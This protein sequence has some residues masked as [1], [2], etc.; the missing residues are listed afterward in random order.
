MNST[1]SRT[2]KKV[3]PQPVKEIARY[4]A[5]SS[6]LLVGSGAS[7]IF[8]RLLTERTLDPIGC[9][10][11]LS[12]LVSGVLVFSF[13]RLHRWAY[14]ILRVIIIASGPNILYNRDLINTP[15]VRRAF[16]LD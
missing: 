11:F 10:L 8:I 4:E 1:S 13:Y 14:S 5:V 6:I 2:M 9:F 7:I 3:V 16:G 12:G 15:E